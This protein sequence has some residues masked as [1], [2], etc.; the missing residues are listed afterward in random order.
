MQDF[1]DSSAYKAQIAGGSTAKNL[2]DF[3]NISVWDFFDCVSKSD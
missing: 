2:I 3:N 1:Y